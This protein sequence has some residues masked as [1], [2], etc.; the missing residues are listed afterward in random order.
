MIFGALLLAGC[1]GRISVAF[2]YASMTQ[3]HIDAGSLQEARRNEQRATMLVST[4]F[5][6]VR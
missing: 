6:L 1:S 5:F 3:A 4:L 2:E